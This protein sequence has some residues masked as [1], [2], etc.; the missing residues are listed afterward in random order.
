MFTS[1]KS[2][3]QSAQCVLA[4]QSTAVSTPSFGDRLGQLV[5]VYSGI[6]PLLTF[7]SSSLFIP[8]KWRGA[9]AILTSA[10]DAVVAGAGEVSAEFKAGKD[11]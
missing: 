3:S 7:L 9:I 4:Q 8:A 1:Y 10:L 6:K 5:K 11:L 2:A